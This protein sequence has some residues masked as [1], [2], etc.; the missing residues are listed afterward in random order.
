MTTVAMPYEQNKTDEV[1]RQPSANVYRPST[2][3]KWDVLQ[4]ERLQQQ[5][6]LDL[7]YR[8]SPVLL[9]KDNHFVI[10]ILGVIGITSLSLI[11]ALSLFGKQLDSP[12]M[13]AVFVAFGV[14]VG[15]RVF[16]TH[17]VKWVALLY[18]LSGIGLWVLALMPVWLR[19]YPGLAEAVFVV[20]LMGTA[21][22]ANRIGRH[23]AY[24]LAESPKIGVE[25][26]ETLKA[27]WDENGWMGYLWVLLYAL[28]LMLSGWM[29]GSMHLWL[30]PVMA[31]VGLYQATRFRQVGTTLRLCWKAIVSWF[32]Y[33]RYQAV[34]FDFVHS[35]T[36]DIGSW[37]FNGFVLTSMAIAV[38]WM[39]GYVYSLSSAISMG[40]AVV[41]VFLVMVAGNRLVTAYHEHGTLFPNP[42]V[43]PGVFR[44]PSG[45]WIRRNLMA[46]GLLIGVFISSVFALSYVPTRWIASDSRPLLA[47]YYSFMSTDM[48]LTKLLNL[49]TRYQP[50]SAAQVIER[51]SLAELR[52]WKQADSVLRQEYLLTKQAADYLRRYPEGWIPL[53]IDAA[54]MGHAQAIWVLLV[55]LLQFFLFPVAVFLLVC[56]TVYGRALQTHHATLDR[57][58]R[59]QT[60][61]QGYV[62]RLRHSEVTS[63]REHLWLGTHATEDYPILLHRA[64]LGEHAHLLGD[65]GS[66]KTALGLAPLMTQL[67]RDADS[68]V[69][70]LDLKGDMTLFENARLDAGERFKFFTNEVEKATYVFNPFTPLSSDHFSLNQVCEVFLSALGLDHGEGYGR[71]YYSRVARSLL[72]RTLREYPDIASFEELR[73]KVGKLVDTQS[74]QKDAFELIA[75]VE[76]LASIQQLNYTAN[77]AVGANG[78][79]MDRVL[80]EREVVYFWLPAAIEMTSVREIA[81]LVLYTLFSSVY[82]H[83]RQELHPT[84]VWVFVDEFQH[85]ASLNFKLILQQARSLGM[86]MILANQTDSDLWTQDVDLRG[87]V[88]ANTRFKQVF[89]VSSVEEREQISRASGQMLYYSG[90][91]DAD[92]MFAGAYEQIGPRLMVNDLIGFS[93]EPETSVVFIGR[94]QGYSQFGGYAFPVRGEYHI[95]FE[96]YVRR[97][98]APWPAPSAETLVA[99]RQRRAEAAPEVAPLAT[100]YILSEE[101]DP[102]G[103]SAAVAASPWAQHLAKLHQ[104]R[105]SLQPKVEDPA[106]VSE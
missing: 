48:S 13:F 11:L 80:K 45:P 75:V 35:E 28:V 36:T 55:T 56:L 47:A 8:V 89:A 2:A 66:G 18:G 49:I 84:K 16:M 41:L 91:V 46:A 20:S 26:R 103:V 1:G 73:E 105:E 59:P 17:R 52:E 79:E 3:P 70:I 32:T 69:V 30:L 24:W 42:V 88:Q 40:L 83:Q 33:H 57:L 38:L 99:R 85:V 6:P 62:E 54:V 68:A 15:G 51:L 101:G 100:A 81:K 90:R 64:I 12:F 58:K 102:P 93:D 9:R 98:S 19:R 34:H 71:S 106:S 95:P 92:G 25:D 50:P 104:E 72:S 94:G 86:G 31:V 60:N 39:N 82:Q 63:A 5:E 29:G 23:Y 10:H 96:E 37:V 78:I 21:F 43:A 67:I 27:Q 77:D 14:L 87:T 65:S 7:G 76:S 22:L 44:S 61:W 97:K 53:M 74:E 4:R